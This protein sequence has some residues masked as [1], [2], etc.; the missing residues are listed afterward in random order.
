[1]ANV[2]KLKIFVLYAIQK[3]IDVAKVLAMW[4]FILK[5]HFSEL[6]Q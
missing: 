1:M 5:I 6:V 4:N 3:Q 2:E